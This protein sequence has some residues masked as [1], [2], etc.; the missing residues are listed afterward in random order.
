MKRK[1][2]ILLIALLALALCFGACGNRNK[3]EDPTPGGEETQVTITSIEVVSGSVSTTI[4]LDATPDFSGI[5]VNVNYSDGTSKQV[6]FADVTIS[7]VDTLTTGKKNVTV[8]YQGFST[9]FEVNV[10]DPDET[11]YIT[12]IKIVP[13][14]IASAYYIDQMFDVSGLQVE[15]TYNTG[16]VSMLAAGEYTYSTVDTSKVGEHTFTV[17]YTANPALT[18][19]TKVEV[20]GIKSIKVI[21]STI[22]SKINVGETLDTSGLQ[23]IVEY[24]D[25][26]TFDVGA[27]ALTIGTIDTTTYGIKDLS[28]TYKGVT[29]KYAIEVVGPVSIS[30]NKGSYPEKVKVLGTYAAPEITG[31]VTFS[32]N[33]QKTLE[34]KDFASISAINTSKAGSQKM[35]VTY[36]GLEAFVY[37]EVVGVSSLEVI[38]GVAN[39]I[40]KGATLSTSDIRVSVKYTDNTTDVV[41]ISELKLGT[42]DTTTGGEKK[43]SVTYLDKSIEYAVKVCV[44]SDIRIEGIANSVQSGKPIDISKMKVYGVYNDNG[45]IDDVELTDGITTNIDSI[46]INTNEAKTLTVTYE[47]VYGS[48]TKDVVIYATAPELESI[49]IRDFDREVLLN[50]AY[51]SENVVVYANYGNGTSVRVYGFEM[52]PVATNVGGNVDFTVTYM[53]KTATETVKVCVITSLRIDNVQSSAPSGEEISIAGMKVYGI[54]NDTAGTPVE[55]KDGRITTNIDELN[56]T[57]L[58]STESRTLT[59]KYVGMYGEHNGTF[60]IGTTAPLLKG[61]EIRDYTAEVLLGGTFT[62]DN[63]SV[64]AIY[65]N[66]TSVRVYSFEMSPVDTNVGGPV[67]FTVT[68]EGMTATKTVKVCVI[69]SI[70][71]EN[72]PIYA[73]SGEEIIITGMKVYGIYNDTAK[74]PIELTEEGTITTNIEE[75]NT[76]YIDSTEP[77]ILSVTY[78][79]VYGEFTTEHKIDTTEPLLE[80]I[81]IKNYTTEVLLG[82]TFTKNDVFVYANYGNGTSV[83]VYNF[84]LSPVETNEGGDVEFTVTYEGMTATKTV[85]V[86]VITSIS[87]ENVSGTVQSGKPIDISEM[88]VYGVYNDSKGT[89]TPEPLP[90]GSYTTNIDDLNADSIKNSMDKRVLVVTYA[91]EITAE[92]DIFATD[93]ELVRIEIESYTTEVLLGGTFTNANVIV[94]AYYENG[95]DKYI[96]NFAMSDVKTNVAGVCTFTVSYTENNVNKIA[97][98]SVKICKIVS[99]VIGGVDGTV[100]SGNPINIDN[101]KVYGVYNDSKGTKTPEPLPVESYTTNIGE[102]NIGSVINS[103]ANRVLVVTY[104]N[105]AKGEFTITAT[106]PAITGIEIVG[107]DTVIGI[108]G[109]YNKG[110]VQVEAIYG[111][112]TRGPITGFGVGNVATNAAGNVTLTVTYEGKTA[113]ATVKVCAIASIE[114]SGV[115]AWVA[116]GGKLDTTNLKVTVKFEGGAPAR[117]V[118]V[119]D[120]AI[121]FDTSVAGDKEISVTYLG[122]TEKFACHVR[123][124]SAINFFGDFSTIRNGYAVDFNN[125]MIDITYTNNDKEQKLL[126]TI[127]GITEQKATGQIPVTNDKGEVTGYKVTVTIKHADAPAIS[128][129]LKVIRLSYIHALT[130]TIPASVFQGDPIDL[131]YIK[132]MLVYD[133]GESFLVEAYNNPLVTYE[134]IDTNTPGSKPV[135]VWYS[136]E[137]DPLTGEPFETNVIVEVKGVTKVEIVEKSVRQKLYQGETIDEVKYLANLLVKITYSDGTYTYVKRDNTRLEIV[138]LPDTANAVPQQ[139]V[140]KYLEVTSEAFTVEIVAKPENADE[141]GYIFGTLRPDGLVQRDSYKGNFKDGASEYRVGDD[142]DYYFYLNVVMLDPSLNIIE[143][144]GKGVPTVATI[145]MNDTTTLTATKNGST[146]TYS[147]EGIDYVVFNSQK[148]AYDFTEAAVGQKFKLDVVPDTS[149]GRFMYDESNPDIMQTHTVRVVN[150]YNIYYGWELNIITNNRT[151]ITEKCWG[152]GERQRYQSD[153]AKAFLAEMGVKIYGKAVERPDSIAGVVLHGNINLQKGDFPDGYFE[154]VKD[155]DGVTKPLMFDQLGLYN[156]LLG[157][158]GQSNSFNIYGNYYT[159]YS[160][161]LPC[162]APKNELNNDDEY[163]SSSLFKVTTSGNAY[164]NID[165]KLGDSTKNPFADYVFNVQDLATRDNDPNSNDQSASERHM[166]GLSCYRVE[167]NVANITNVNVDAFMTSLNIGKANTTVNLTH[168]KFYNAW[169]THVYA[170]NTNTYQTQHLKAEK[171]VTRDGLFGVKLTANS[172]LLAK[173]GGPVI[174]AQTVH[175][176]YAANQSTAVDV[177]L[178]ASSEIWSYVTGQEAWFV[179]TNQVQLATTLKSMIKPFTVAGQPGFISEGGEIQGV[180]TVNLVM[181]NMGTTAT[182]GEANTGYNGTFTHGSEVGLRMRN[183]QSKFDQ[184]SLYYNYMLEQYLAATGGIA[185]IFQSGKDATNFMATGGSQTAFYNPM[186]P[187][188]VDYL[189]QGNGSG[190]F[191]PAGTAFF[192]TDA[193]YLGLY[194]QGMGIVMQYYH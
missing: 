142:N 129:D 73:P 179:A 133:N 178:D 190:G 151:D 152:E 162:V 41:G 127:D 7:A 44:V 19:S 70:E 147:N 106:A 169:Q 175:P 84:E 14:S 166:R 31:Y 96:T 124:V 103:T 119:S 184:N 157:Q 26:R 93:P 38:S 57:Y 69:T 58:N 165:T 82:G 150:G 89:K 42:V 43:L 153:L 28:I 71:V 167:E 117:E 80:S 1:L 138:S 59:V 122:K 5:K 161:D 18:A 156:L 32:D 136:G 123:G 149:D 173:C 101:I 194:Y 16:K 141:G 47:G 40:A 158:S 145:T 60:T 159:I 125:I 4:E 39:E 107:Y 183:S 132:I 62:N 74:T 120:V 35:T 24:A 115:P 94:R 111:N 104:E 146:I 65:G 171:E 168:V 88:K 110:S 81:E 114:L 135:K 163:S 37:V 53:G 100:Q 182:M 52:T 50:N 21:T 2:L 189:L 95:T 92:K 68:Y 67:D 79:G 112:G 102:L 144:D 105:G 64:F 86:C 36:E 140:V 90:V 49:E 187:N 113:T 11:A 160:Y 148:N 137:N 13:G 61:I 6:G 128:K 10:I 23:V 78:T 54:Y 85:K 193:R 188:L 174:I 154:P 76:T 121:A 131:S 9:Q 164:T 176:E 56:S 186:D 172:S 12:S 155:N 66:G 139:L 34:A 48:F 118:A 170:Y 108:G 15:A 116:K 17:T 134:N 192:A 8:K 87:I 20:L 27:T 72:L 83:R 63:V 97:S 22:A 77:R 75:L 55:L 130:G 3:T 51:G 180:Q 185:P 30:V 25:G 46:D 98:A 33:T 109:E 181:I 45:S 29:I 191:A 91:G 99:L 143:Q 126:S 177:N